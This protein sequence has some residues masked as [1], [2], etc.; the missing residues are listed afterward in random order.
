MLILER[1]PFYRMEKIHRH[2]I[3]SQPPRGICQVEN[4]VLVLAHSDNSAR[5]SREPRRTNILDRFD[6]VFPSVCGAD[7][8][9]E[10]L[11]GVEIVIDP[12]RASA[13]EGLRFRLLHQSER[14][15]NLK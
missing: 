15:T 1:R 2:R 7:F 6:A 8:W 14:Q 13:L 10:A 11:A 12:A 5:A 9:I 4:I 3:D